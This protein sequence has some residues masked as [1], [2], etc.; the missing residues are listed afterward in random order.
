VTI[1]EFDSAGV[2]GMRDIPLAPL[3]DVRVIRGALSDLLREGGED[4]RSDDYVQVQLTD[5]DSQLDAMARIRTV[6]PNAL[7]LLY[8][9]RATPAAANAA[10]LR[11]RLSTGH[12]EMFCSF[13]EAVQGVPLSAAQQAHLSTVIERAQSRDAD[14]A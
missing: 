1:V 3:R 4:P 12:R 5:S 10:D 7:Q 11:E 9:R 8:E 14:E 2:T 6:Y 13:F